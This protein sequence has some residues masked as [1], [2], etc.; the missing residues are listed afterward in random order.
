[1]IEVA[2]STENTT[3]VATAE[4]A[5][6]T[7][8]ATAVTTEATADASTEVKKAKAAK[9]GT[10]T[11]VKTDKAEKKEAVRR[12]DTKKFK[13]IQLV[14]S[15]LAAG[16]ARKDT[17]LALQGDGYGLTSACANTY[18]QNIKSGQKGWTA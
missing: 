17:L 8:V 18:Y 13:A 16:I 3:E 15:N 11:T 1:M 5:V 4:A 2:A 14:T 12:E 9:K 6:T 10:A 7:E